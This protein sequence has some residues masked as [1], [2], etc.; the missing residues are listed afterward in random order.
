MSGYRHLKRAGGAGLVVD[1][2]KIVWTPY[3]AEREYQSFRG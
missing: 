3:N 2:G 1:P